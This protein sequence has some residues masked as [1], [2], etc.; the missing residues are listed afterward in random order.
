MSARPLI[1]KTQN[2]NTGRL[3]EQIAEGFLFKKGFELIE[4]NFSTRFGEIDLICRDKDILVFVEVKT[5][6]SLDFGTPEEMFT[7]NKRRRVMNMGYVYTKGKEVKCRIDMIAI[8]LDENNNLLS[9]KHYENLTN[10]D[11]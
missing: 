10:L 3:G 2:R 6:R 7:Q 9:L 1:M 8:L 5:K 4:R 11:V